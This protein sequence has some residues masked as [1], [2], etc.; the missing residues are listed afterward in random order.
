MDDEGHEEVVN[1]YDAVRFYSVTLDATAAP[2]FEIRCKHSVTAMGFMPVHNIFM[3][4]VSSG[5]LFRYE[6]DHSEFKVS[7]QPSI[8]PFADKSK[9]HSILFLEADEDA[10]VIAVS[11][12]SIGIWYVT[13]FLTTERT[14]T[15]TK[16]S[17]M[18]TSAPYQLEACRY[19]HLSSDSA[20][21]FL[22]CLYK[23]SDSVVHCGLFTFT[24][25]GT[26]SFKFVHEYR[27][28]ES[29]SSS[30]SPKIDSVVSMGLTGT[31]VALGTSRNKIVVHNCKSAQCVAILVDMDDAVLDTCFHK[32]LPLLAVCS[33][34]KVI[35]Y[36][37]TK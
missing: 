7:S 9:V 16:T 30:P 3:L 12:T 27:R 19:L 24:I 25:Q 21:L 18:A 15:L 11:N 34:D 5:E 29:I 4:A 1:M 6:I 13:N 37:Q 36:Y 2:L 33:K 31:Y 35:I 23:S 10:C 32:T 22:L 14:S 17:F 28:K 20:T 8:V 26:I